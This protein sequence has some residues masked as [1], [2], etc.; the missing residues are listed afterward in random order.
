MAYNRR[1]IDPLDLQPRKAVGVA[2]PFSGRAVFN[3]TYQTKDAIRNN[4]INFFLTG[5]NERVFNLNFGAGLRNLLF[6][7]ITQ[8]RIDEIRELI[9]ENLQLY[10]PRV[11]VRNLTLDSALDQ[12][13]VQFQLRY[14][15]SETNIEDEVAINFE[16]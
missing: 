6:E 3:S 10:F 8:D 11:I 14:A 13:L 12:N 9:L 4:L 7:N 1:K 16:V 15:V 2:L 5:K